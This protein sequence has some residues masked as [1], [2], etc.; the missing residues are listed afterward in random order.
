V[1]NSY[2]IEAYQE[3]ISIVNEEKLLLV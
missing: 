1:L 3:V 2:M